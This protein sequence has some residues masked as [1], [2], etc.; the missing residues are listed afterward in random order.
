MPAA[1]DDNFGRA[2]LS[3][4]R[5][6][7]IEGRSGVRM[8][9]ADLQSSI[10]LWA[11]AFSKEA[12]AS[13]KSGP[14]LLALELTLESVV[15][16]LGA[17]ASGYPVLPIDAKEWARQA[18]ALIEIMRP[19]LCWLPEKLKNKD[20]FDC[21][22]VP[23]IQGKFFSL[24]LQ[25][26]ADML[27]IPSKGACDHSSE[28]PIRLYAPTSGS[29]GLPAIVKV[30]DQN[31]IVNTNDIVDS[32]NLG[33]DD[34]A[35]LCLPLS[36]CFGAS[37]L[38]T[39]LWA[40]GSVVIDDRLM[41]VEKVL[42]SMNRYG[43]TSFAGVPTSYT[44]LQQHS[45]ALERTFPTLKRWLQAGGYLASS[46]VHAFRAAHP[47]IV[48]MIMYGQTEATSRIATFAVEGDYPQGCVGYPMASLRVE[49]RQPDMQL[50]CEVGQQGVVWVKGESVSAGYM[51]SA[52]GQKFVDGWL[53]TGDIGYLL[54]DGRLCITGRETGFIKIRGRRVG[55]QE[56][57]ALVWKNFSLQCCACAI[58]DQVQGEVIGLYLDI[59]PHDFDDTH[60]LDLEWNQRVRSVLPAHWSLGSM[61]FGSLP[62]TP[63]GKIDR[64]RCQEL[65]LEVRSRQ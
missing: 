18:P 31:L 13:E 57:E 46:V 20:I 17:L 39:H 24:D 3:R 45:Q 37:V 16:Y 43:C 47:H 52:T 4:I 58:P 8:A 50:P 64:V 23:I 49:I 61:A 44:F 65:L 7:V 53:N 27:E 62:L 9:A 14:I 15:A 48:F 6:E 41:F 56:V 42:D 22:S 55:S 59:Q 34:C 11:N 54:A 33:P 30:T 32:Q 2:L 10:S 19:V 63:N 26:N 29:T 21:R 51:H 40:G 28:M 35:L 60:R 25:E 12:K 1:H 36:Y 5:G 38:H